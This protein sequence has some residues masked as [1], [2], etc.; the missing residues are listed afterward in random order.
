MNICMTA[1]SS[2]L[3]FFQGMKIIGVTHS[4]KHLLD[5][6]GQAAHVGVLD[7]HG[8]GCEEGSEHVVVE[9]DLCGREAVVAHVGGDRGEPACKDELPT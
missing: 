1:A 5:V 6:L 7:D 3:I 4:A 2:P 9:R 8:E